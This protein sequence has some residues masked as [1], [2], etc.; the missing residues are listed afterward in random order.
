MKYVL[1]DSDNRWQEKS[2]GKVTKPFPQDILLN[3]KNLKAVS[4][5]CGVT[6]IKEHYNHLRCF[7]IHI[8]IASFHRK[9]KKMYQ[10]RQFYFGRY[11]SWKYCSVAITWIINTA[12]TMQALV[13]P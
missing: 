6:H 11:T 4:Q 3:I 12:Y 13:S 7:K 9:N 8:H 5:S 10:C 1:H 2:L